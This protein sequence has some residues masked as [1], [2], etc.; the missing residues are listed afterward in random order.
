MFMSKSKAYSLIE[1]I[2]VM[3]ILA[4]VVSFSVSQITHIKR[5]F[6]FNDVEKL[7]I[8]FSYLQQ[9]SIASNCQQ[10]LVFDEAHNSFS[11]FGPSDKLCAQKLNKGVHFGFITGV[12]GPPSRPTDE[13][14]KAITFTPSKEKITVC[15]FP[16]GK[17]TPGTVYLVDEN[18]TVMGA[19]TCPI[20][21][22]S[23]MRKYRFDNKKWVV[24]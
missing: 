20:S 22:V 11:Y 14:K 6:L 21:G 7:F 16:D 3:A 9:K 10:D 5:Y 4:I 23:Y 18:K 17:V 19:L 12:K 8:T 1:L 13:I 15:F 24:V 2:V